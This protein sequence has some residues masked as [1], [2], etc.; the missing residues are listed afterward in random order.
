MLILPHGVRVATDLPQNGLKCAVDIVIPL[1]EHH[2]VGIL[3]WHSR[4]WLKAMSTTWRNF[5]I[6]ST[7]E[8][9]H[10]RCW[11][12]SLVLDDVHRLMHK[13]ESKKSICSCSSRHPISLAKNCVENFWF[14]GCLVL[15][16]ARRRQVWTPAPLR[17]TAGWVPVQIANARAT[18]TGNDKK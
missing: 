10:S 17:T 14:R 11:K 16:I 9:F 13:L 7:L 1:L 12:N 3:A 8:V 15:E 5:L 4:H 18:R 2:G 6:V